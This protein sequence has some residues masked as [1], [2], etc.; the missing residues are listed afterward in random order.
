MLAGYYEHCF[1]YLQYAVDVSIVH[2]LNQTVPI[3]SNKVGNYEIEIQRFPYPSFRDDVFLLSMQ[4]I[5]PL[6]L[7]LSFIYPVINTTKSIVVEKER[8]LKVW[9]LL[10]SP[11]SRALVTQIFL[12]PI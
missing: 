12:T 5:L 11:Y 8:R 3:G 6:A 4:G 2:Y 10:Y 1:L 7:M 9:R